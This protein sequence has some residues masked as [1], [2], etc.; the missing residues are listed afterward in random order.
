MHMQMTCANGCAICIPVMPINIGNIVTSGMK[1]KPP[2]KH[3]R[4]NA[5]KLFP[6]LWKHIFET[7]ANGKKGNAKHIKRKAVLPISITSASFLNNEIIISAF[8]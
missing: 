4:I 6:I 8:I 5:V 7:A 3:A 2:C 1:I